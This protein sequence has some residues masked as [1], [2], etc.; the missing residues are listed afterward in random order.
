MTG[1]EEYLIAVTEAEDDFDWRL[2]RALKQL[3]AELGEAGKTAL[4]DFT[5]DLDDMIAR[6]TAALEQAADVFFWLI[7]V[8]LN[9][10]GVA[11]SHT[12]Q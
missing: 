6:R 4:A 7:D 12:L 10:D 2:N 8:F 1:E 3:K 11:A 9:A 5:A